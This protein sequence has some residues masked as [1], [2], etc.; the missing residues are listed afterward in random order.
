M[1]CSTFLVSELVACATL[2]GSREKKQRMKWA[3]R[4]LGL[5]YMS[6]FSTA[7]ADAL[8]TVSAVKKVIEVEIISDTM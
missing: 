2:D 7:D 8:N 4:T 6:Q 3:L 1:T 5:L